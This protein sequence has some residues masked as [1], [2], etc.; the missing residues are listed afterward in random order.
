MDHIQ[1][2]RFLTPLC[3]EYVNKIG[4]IRNKIKMEIGRGRVNQVLFMQ[5]VALPTK[6]IGSMAYLCGIILEPG[7]LEIASKLFTTNANHH[8]PQLNV[9][10]RIS[11]V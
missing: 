10:F 9:V 2:L 4:I 7:D 1:L 5:T 11:R 3:T 6:S 8:Y